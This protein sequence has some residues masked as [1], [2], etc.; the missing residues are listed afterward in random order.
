MAGR[1]KAGLGKARLTQGKVYYSEK[2]EFEMLVLSR[3]IRESISIGNDVKVTVHSVNG[4]IV[5]LAIDAP[6][7][8]KI[9]RDELIKHPTKEPN[10]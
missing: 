1:G 5:R 7:H 9:L 4:S 6:S 8:I 2:K 10:Q 3:K